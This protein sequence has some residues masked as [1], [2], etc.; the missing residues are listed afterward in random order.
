MLTSLLIVI[1][2]SFIGVG[3]PDSVLGTAWPAMAQSFSLPI[4][5]AGYIS[6]TVSVGTIVSSLLS[7][8]LIARLGT[9]L[10]TAV[11]TLLTAIAL[12]GFALCPH[13]ALF[14]LLAIPLGLGAGAIDTA[15]NSFVA[16]HYSAAKMN[17]MQCFYGIGVAASPF[18]MALALGNE[19]DWRRG[20]M[21]VALIQWGLTALCFLS[22]PLWHR[23]QQQLARETV[24]D[25]KPVPI[26][27]LISL[28][29]VRLSC[30]SL[31]SACALELTAG[32]WS[33]SFFVHARGMEKDA[34]ALMAMLFYI[35]LALS[36][37]LSGM[38]VHRLGRRRVLRLSL[39]LLPIAILVYMVPGQLVLAGI[40][41]F[42]IGFGIG[43]VYPN[44]V[45]L[46]P[47]FVEK[48]AVQGVM[49]VQQAATYGGILL[50]PW[51]F[52]VLAQ[53]ISAAMLPYY[54]MVLVGLYA[55]ALLALMKKMQSS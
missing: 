35:G 32:S 4:S 33:A 52:G 31:F 11:S 3:L 54:L 27:Q 40:G 2:I 28:P 18:I 20:Y 9:G 48:E 24:E 26:K 15:L 10:L 49:G 23:V 55:I 29:A 17:F 21:T 19:G 5:L 8:R 1:F 22:L 13:P 42:F 38:V 37:F 45:H 47:L 30:F 46:T 34:A 12:L 39:L 36:R 50:M 44:L 6:A 41:L 16:L 7:A 43:P 53:A 51:L 25:A 14:F